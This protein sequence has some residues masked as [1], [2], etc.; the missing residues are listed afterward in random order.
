MSIAPLVTPKVVQTADQLHQVMK[1]LGHIH[2]FAIDTESDSLYSY[3]PKVCLIQLSVYTEG[4]ESE[5]SDYL[6]DPLAIKD[7]LPLGEL[8]SNPETEV[9]MHAAENDLL[10]LQREFGIEV[11]KLFDTQLA[12]RILGREKVG[13]ASILS[14]EFGVQSNKRMQRTDWGKRPLTHEQTTY[15]QKD[16]HYLLP[17]RSI[18]RDELERTGR[19]QEAKEA[20]RNLSQTDY[21][22]HETTPRTMWQM[23][24]TRDVPR[25]DH[26][27]LE[28]LWEWREEEAQRRDVPPFKVMRN[29]ALAELAVEQPHTLDDIRQTPGVGKT[30]VQRYGKQLLEAILIGK[31]RRIPPLPES[32]PRPD[33]VND[34][35]VQ[36]LYDS[37]RH[38]RTKTAEARGVDP[39]IVMANATLLEIAK[40][41]PESISELQKLDDIGTWKAET[42]GKEILDILQR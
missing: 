19:W 4:N 38:W 26:G 28:A 27:V 12:A 16:T 6:I 30:S 5:V 22:M 15:A 8:L 14:D 23:K 9:I 25:E 13:L 42:Y 40:Q 41:R 18:L 33:Y 2:L 36:S 20:F 11:Q 37:L 35:K 32:N 7:L 39:D 29:Q 34:R 21:S 1:E 31:Q 10:L 24:E 17:L 3:Y